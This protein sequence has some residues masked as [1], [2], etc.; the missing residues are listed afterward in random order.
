VPSGR[1]ASV[2]ALLLMSLSFL[3]V[4]IV[5]AALSA[6]SGPSADQGDRGHQST[7]GTAASTG[8]GAAT[9]G[10]S[11]HGGTSGSAG[12]SLGGSGAA[13]AGG[14][15]SG[16]ARIAV[17]FVGLAS[18]DEL[19][20]SAAYGDCPR[21]ASRTDPQRFVFT[22][23][24]AEH[25]TEMFNREFSRLIDERPFYFDAFEVTAS[26]PLAALQVEP[27]DDGDGVVFPESI[28]P[29]IRAAFLN[30]IIPESLTVSSGFAGLDQTLNSYNGAF[31]VAIPDGGDGVFMHEFGHVFGLPHVLTLDPWTY[32]HCGG[33]SIAPPTSG[34]A[35]DVSWIWAHLPYV[36]NPDCSQCPEAFR[37]Q[38]FNTPYYGEASRTAARCWL[39]ERRLRLTCQV[40]VDLAGGRSVFCDGKEGALSCRCPDEVTTFEALDCDPG[41]LTAAYEMHCPSGQCPIP[42]RADLACRDYG[43]G[44]ASCLCPDGSVETAPDCQSLQ[45]PARAPT[46]CFGAPG[47]EDDWHS[48]DSRYTCE[49]IETGY[50]CQCPGDGTAPPFAVA[51]C[52]PDAKPERDAAAA[53]GCGVS[54]CSVPGRPAVVCESLSTDPQVQC[55]CPGGQIFYLDGDCAGAENVSAIDG[56]C[57]G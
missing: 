49:A 6:C 46:L 27:G 48:S 22:Q 16:E 39:E 15:S 56:I 41:A 32:E 12:T 9:S 17:R 40:E 47:C 31:L 43:A 26:S 29:L 14:A 33:F 38:T 52:A 25:V 7:G 50:R 35:C 24:F 34:C 37:D 10:I 18:G 53:L 30:V 55:R 1:S 42:D 5:A 51:S 28:R 57:D 19:T 23:C 11:G 4:F 45:S 3:R 21:V 2:T 44:I 36:D 54:T 20:A 8:D 13:A